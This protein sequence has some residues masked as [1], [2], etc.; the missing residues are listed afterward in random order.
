MVVYDGHVIIGA[1]S[2]LT[3]ED[4]L[5]DADDVN[6]NVW[7]RGQFKRYGIE[8]L[9]KNQGAKRSDVEKH[10]KGLTSDQVSSLFPSLP[11]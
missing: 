5:D 9:Y 10:F 7:P 6:N 2:Q 1:V 11:E 3:T 4:D 8:E